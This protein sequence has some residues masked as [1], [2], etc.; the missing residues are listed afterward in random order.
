LVSDTSQRCALSSTLRKSGLPDAYRQAIAEA[1]GIQGQLLGETP[2]DTSER[3]QFDLTQKV[4]AR[5][6]KDL[7]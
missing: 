4:L 6:S 5:L 2:S 7:N 3:E 1:A